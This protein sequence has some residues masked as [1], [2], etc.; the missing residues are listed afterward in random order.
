MPLLPENVPGE[1]RVVSK[2]R[3]LPDFITLSPAM[4]VCAAFREIVEDLEP[5]VHQ[6]SPVTLYARSGEKVDR[7]YYLF[8]VLQ[9]R[10]AVI[11][12]KSDV[13]WVPLD[14]IPGPT[15][16]AFT[17]MSPHLTLDAQRIAGRHVWRGD[18]H[19]RLRVFFSDAVGGA[20]ER[21]KLKKLNLVRTDVL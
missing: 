16:L 9:T 21:L 4:R 15:Y 17:R 8:K 10:D 11:D 20:I 2:H 5:G 3:T 7:H 14:S 13:E 18:K 12:E 1:A 19:L 6:F